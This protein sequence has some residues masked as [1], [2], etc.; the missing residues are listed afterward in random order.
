M[1]NVKVDET[2]LL[3]KHKYH[4]RIYTTRSQSTFS[5]H[6]NQLL[7]LSGVHGLKDFLCSAHIL[8]SFDGHEFTLM[9]VF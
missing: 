9:E 5:T 4:H 7:S 1:N 6:S 2:L 8:E 3:H